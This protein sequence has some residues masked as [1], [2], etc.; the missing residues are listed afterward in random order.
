MNC[1]QCGLYLPDANREQ[2]PRCGWVRMNSA[3]AG[4]PTPDYDPWTNTG[5]PPTPTEAPQQ[6]A[7]PRNA[8][9]S[10]WQPYTPAPTPP[11]MYPPAQQP[12][13]D[14]G[15]P[16]GQGTPL[17]MPSYGQPAQPSVP[18]YGQVAPPSVPMYGQ[19]GQYGQYAPPS[20]P[21]YGQAAP[22]SMGQ[23]PGWGAPF[24][25]PQP[26]KKSMTGLIWALV[27]V[28][29]VV[30][31]GAGGL[32]A[33]HANQQTGVTG[34]STPTATA[35]AA[36][37]TPSNTLF[38]DSFAD[39][40]TGWANDSHCSYGSGGY[41]IKD[42]YICYAPAGSFADATISATSK[43]ISGSQLN[44]YGIAFRISGQLD[45]EFDIDSGGQWAVAKCGSSNCTTLVDFTPNSAIH[46]GLNVT[47][48]L[49]VAMKG[50]HFV[51][52]VNGTQ[53]GETTDA[54]YASGKVGISASDSTE[55]V[56]SN[57][58]IASA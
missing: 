24:P 19:Y 42:G 54:T 26:P 22:P 6:Y 27:I 11:S 45:Y 28:V 21:M 4:M 43:Q 10:G 51:F 25:P 31:G 47:N 38:Q 3:G 17:G 53:V 29:V 52:S 32:L 20:V 12:I 8:P 16:F 50:S 18:M 14:Q 37:A 34:N 58:Q 1:P 23:Q 33:L 55:V 5:A 35:P 56:Y 30:I 48:T 40:S 44:P 13:P 36:T 2:C 15:S 49:T 7:P 41:H 9:A 39:P 46:T 57:F